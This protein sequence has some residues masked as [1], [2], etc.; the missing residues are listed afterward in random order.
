[1]STDAEH[2]FEENVGVVDK[3]NEEDSD[4]YNYHSE[5]LKSPISSSDDEE[6]EGSK[7]PVYP[8]FDESAKFGFV[9]L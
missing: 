5:E 6:E 8:Q 7:I 4:F 3:T 1:M 2:D 9:S